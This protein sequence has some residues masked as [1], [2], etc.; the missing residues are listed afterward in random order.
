MSAQHKAALAQGRAEGR[1]V[2]NY[3]EALDRSRPRRGRKRTPESVKKRL[4]AIEAEMP[5]ASPLVRL[6]L[7]QERMDLEK[8]L[9]QLG[10]KVD[11]TAL[12]AAF[13]KTAGKYSERKG[14]SYAA[15]RQLGV[16][17][18]TLKKAGITR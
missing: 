14:I 8:E 5:G 17:A 3:L 1:A 7:V 13:V 15:W 4:T 12:E 16:S 9:E 6:Q 2:K 18:E 10:T 11:L